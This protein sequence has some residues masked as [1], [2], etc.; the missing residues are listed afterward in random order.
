MI[1]G[2]YQVNQKYDWTIERNRC[3]LL[4]IVGLN[5]GIYQCWKFLSIFQVILVLPRKATLPNTLIM[6][7]V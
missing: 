3:D 1:V 2:Y 5:I 7:G 4:P 6:I